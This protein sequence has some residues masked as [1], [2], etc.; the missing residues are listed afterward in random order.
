LQAEIERLFDIAPS[1]YTD[2]DFLLFERLKSALN[3]GRVR[4]AEP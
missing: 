2:E 4:A 1:V 3:E